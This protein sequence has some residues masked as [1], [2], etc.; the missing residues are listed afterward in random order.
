[1]DVVV[2]FVCYSHSPE[3]VL[4]V[5]EFQ[6]AQALLEGRAELLSQPVPVPSHWAN[7]AH[8]FDLCLTFGRF[9]TA[10]A[11]AERGVKGCRLE[12]HHLMRKQ[13]SEAHIVEPRKAKAR[14]VFSMSSLVCLLFVW[15]FG[16]S[17]FLHNGVQIWKILLTQRQG[18]ISPSLSFFADDKSTTDPISVHSEFLEHLCYIV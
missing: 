18:A 7:P 11:M 10:W 9:D 12:A 14:A 16:L 17:D 5:K 8:L 6:I 2:D 4:G 15:S 3:T 1:M 13:M